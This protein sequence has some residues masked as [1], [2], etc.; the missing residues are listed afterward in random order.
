MISTAIALGFVSGIIF[1]FSRKRGE[2]EIVVE[3]SI[4][5]IK[6]SSVLCFIHESLLFLKLCSILSRSASNAHKSLG[7]AIIWVDS[8]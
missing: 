2:I 4:E 7:T 5:T 1:S 8:K 3:L 6:T